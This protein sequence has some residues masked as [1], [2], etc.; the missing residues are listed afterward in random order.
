M[1][2]GIGLRV[3]VTL[4]ELD[5]FVV[6]LQLGVDTGQIGKSFGYTQGIA[7]AAFE[8]QRGQQRAGG[9]GVVALVVLH[10]AQV[11]EHGRL[12]PVIAPGAAQAQRFVVAQ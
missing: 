12:P 10:H 11:V 9:A 7:V 1:A 5:G 3:Q 2:G 8:A 6:L 4:E